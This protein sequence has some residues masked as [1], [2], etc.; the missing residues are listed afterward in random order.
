[1]P[2]MGTAHH[3]P[4]TEVADLVRQLQQLPPS[5]RAA[6][7]RLLDDSNPR[8]A[9]D[10]FLPFLRKVWP[11]FIHGGHHKIMA[12][13]FERI[14]RGELK[15]FII[16]LPPRHTKSKFASVL[17]PAWYLGKHPEEKI[18]ECSHTAS[19]AQ[20]F[21]RELRNLVATPEYRSIFPELK[22][23]Q[24][25]RAAGRWN[26]SRGGQY[27]AVGK[28]GAAAGRG[29]NLVI[30][31]DPHSEQDVLANAKAEFEK[32]WQW[33]LSGPRQRLQPGAA[34]LVVM[35]RWG[36]LDLTGQ[37]IKQATEDEHTEPEEWEVIQLPAILPSGNS[38]WPAFWPREEMERTKAT[39][40]VSKWMAQ[41]QQSPTSDQGAI[42]KRE[43]W[44]DWTRE[45]PPVCE[46]IVQAWDTAYSDKTSANRSACVTW[47]EFCAFH[48]SEQ[49]RKVTGIILLDVWC[50]RLNFPEL[51]QKALELYMQ[52]KPWAL[53]VEAKATGTTLIQELQA[54][55]VR[56][57]EAMPAH[58]G[59]D[60]HTRTNAVASMFSSGSVWA[61]LRCKWAQD[62]QEEMA[63]FPYGESDDMHDAA[64]WGLLRVRRGGFRI[65]SDEPEEEWK[66]RPRRQYY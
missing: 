19:L 38:L 23:S 16:N 3:P 9:R 8:Q 31:D 18:L 14:A 27:F 43:W 47:G 28:T 57:I 37:L 53:V 15:R 30:V 20:D 44:Q 21:G 62:L 46:R 6:V 65:P 48:P 49:Q 54:V 50:G 42:I 24:D 26:T 59:N 12:E 4:D 1:M 2:C 63:A 39:L 64:V 25:A 34:I 22:L 58:R 52:W 40:P 17:F 60:K 33:Y 7:Q 32:T 55:G 61:P 29:G 56:Y 36:E 45:N 5:A 13:A 11:E 41:C 51:K 35:T 10:H 66:P